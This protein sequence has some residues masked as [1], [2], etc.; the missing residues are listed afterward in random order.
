MSYS[1]PQKSLTS[2]PATL[3]SYLSMLRAMR[4]PKCQRPAYWLITEN[5]KKLNYPSIEKF[6][7]YVF[8]H[9]HI[10]H[11]GLCIEKQLIDGK[12]VHSVYDG[13]NRINAILYFLDNPYDVFPKKYKKID[14]TID[15]VNELTEQDKES[16]KNII[17]SFDYETLFNNCNDL[18]L[19]FGAKYHKDEDGEDDDELDMEEQPLAWQLYNIIPGPKQRQL[20]KH[21]KNWKKSFGERINNGNKEARNFL[22]IIILASF[23]EHYTPEEL[24]K[25][26]IANKYKGTKMTEND[27]YAAKLCYIYV[28]VT[29]TPIKHKLLSIIKSYYNNR[30]ND[31]EQVT[32]YSVGETE[33]K[34]NAFDFIVAFTDYCS[35]EYGLFK[36]FLESTDKESSFFVLYQALYKEKK[37]ICKDLNDVDFCSNNVND[38]ISNICNACEILQECVDSLYLP[39]CNEKLFNSSSNKRL[40]FTKKLPLQAL[41]FS[42]I[43]QIK[44]S[45]EPDIDM[46]KSKIKVILY[47]DELYKK[48]G[49]QK[50]SE[51][52]ELKNKIFKPHHP[53]INVT[54]GHW[55]E[56]MYDIK[57]NP[58]ILFNKVSSVVQDLSC[59]LTPNIMQQLTSNLLNKQSNVRPYI[60]KK[61]RRKLTILDKFVMG[62]FYFRKMAQQKKSDEFSNEHMVPFSARH[63]GE[64]DIDRLGN[65]FPT[66]NTINSSRKNGD[67]SIYYK[68]ETYDDFSKYLQ[69]ILYSNEEYKTMVEYEKRGSNVC[70][71][72]KNVKI[73]NEICDR[74]EKYYIDKFITNMFEGIN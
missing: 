12:F 13:N 31:Y 53:L 65:L 51:Q 20:K 29:N 34:L 74:N 71:V 73:Y 2:T 56:W 3:R 58:D 38:F 6:V 44:T 35:N 61:K 55:T 66:K 43:M 47:Y 48:I 36:T 30:N 39:S 33:N 8:E 63:D 68:R 1:A 26:F 11:E 46:M 24:A 42:I 41:L 54:S 5:M 57:S 69:P 72:I 59:N 49:G 7:E 62:D 52:A 37:D 18:S 70:P 15:S 23:Y 64:I 4:K 67:L 45:E 17:H 9:Y 14:A 22:E 27:L 21:I 19:L 28:R 10:G 16:F 40:V 60:E 25:I 50:G 32:Q